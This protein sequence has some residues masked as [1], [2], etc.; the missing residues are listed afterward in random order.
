LFPRPPINGAGFAPAPTRSISST[1]AFKYWRVHL[2]G[3]SR[4]GAL[5]KIVMLT[6][7]FYNKHFVEEFEYSLPPGFDRSAKR[8]AV[9]GYPSNHKKFVEGRF[10]AASGDPFL[11]GNLGRLHERPPSDE[12]DCFSQLVY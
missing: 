8:E 9:A 4:V 1:E 6:T 11:P 10:A 7:A 12:S 2:Y 3:V 5:F